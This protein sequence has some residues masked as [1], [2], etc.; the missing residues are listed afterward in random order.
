MLPQAWTAGARYAT[1]KLSVVPWK[2]GQLAGYADGYAVTARH[3]CAHREVDLVRSGARAE[4]VRE[5]LECWFEDVPIPGDSPD[6][7]SGR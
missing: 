3:V 5:V 4:V 2:T 6:S 1:A 7:R